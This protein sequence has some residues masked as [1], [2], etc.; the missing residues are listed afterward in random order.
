MTG[1]PPHELRRLRSVA[2]HDQHLAEL[3]RRRLEGEPLQYLEGSTAFVS[4]DLVVDERVLIPRPETEMLWDLACSLVT[5]PSVIVDLCTGSGALAIALA[6]RFPDARVIGTDLSDD[7]LAVA[8]ANGAA[9]AP[10]VEWRQGDLF[11]ALDPSLRGAVDLMVANPPYVSEAEWDQLPVDVRHE[12]RM[13]LVAGETGLEVLSRIAAE[14]ADW[15]KPGGR[16]V[17]EI[18]ES[19]GDAV[20]DMFSGYRSSAVLRDLADRDRYLAVLR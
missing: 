7:A 5:Q 19:Q 11:A 16:L 1:L 8:R 17:C 13:A 15:L 9:L 18:G 14:A 20:L 4:F 3:V 2:E 10:G 6:R 12:P